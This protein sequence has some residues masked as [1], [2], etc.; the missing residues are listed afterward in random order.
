MDVELEDV[1]EYVTG[2]TE[3]GVVLEISQGSVV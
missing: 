1:V 2:V 3:T